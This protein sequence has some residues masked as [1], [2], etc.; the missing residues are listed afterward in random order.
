MML[1]VVGVDHWRGRRPH[2]IVINLRR[3]III[4]IR[5]H[6]IRAHLRAFP[7]LHSLIFNF[8]FPVGAGSFD[9]S[10]DL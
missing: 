3:V 10:N 1:L 8:H 6:I 4:W 2:F 9:C 5:V 7:G